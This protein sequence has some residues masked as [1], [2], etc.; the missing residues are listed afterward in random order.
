MKP[1]TTVLTINLLGV[2]LVLIELKLINYFLYNEL[3]GPI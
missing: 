2:I 3:L 1:T